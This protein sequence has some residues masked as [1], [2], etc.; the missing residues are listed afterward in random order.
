MNG[1]ESLQC[2]L[3]RYRTHEGGRGWLCVIDR[4]EDEARRTAQSWAGWNGLEITASRVKTL[5][6]REGQYFDMPD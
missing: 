5:P 1:Q 4:S 3:L 2:F 6:L